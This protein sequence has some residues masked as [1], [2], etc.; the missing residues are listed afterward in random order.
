[1]NLEQLLE[2]ALDNCR[3]DP[4]RPLLV[5]FSGGPDSL[6]LLDALARLGFPLIAAHFDHGL[7]PAPR[8]MQMW[9]ASRLA[10][11]LGVP[12]VTERQDVAVYA[13]QARLSIE[14]AA[15][16]LRYQFLFAQARRAFC[17]GS[18]GR[19]HRR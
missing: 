18:G 11:R 9:F 12:F 13:R 14:E 1:M 5:G 15:R 7:R 8:R 10:D 17:A 2:V 16:E 3:L 6:C 19:P 4:A